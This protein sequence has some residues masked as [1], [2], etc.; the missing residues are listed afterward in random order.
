MIYNGLTSGV[1]LALLPLI[2]LA[3]KRNPQCQA[4]LA[5]RLGHA[6]A[7]SRFSSG[8]WPKIWIH[9]VSVGEVKV[10]DAIIRALDDGGRKAAIVLTTTTATGQRYAARTLGHR[11][12][13]CFA[14]LD[15]WSVTGRFLAF[16]RPDLL[17]CM[18]TEIW[19]NWIVRTHRI[20][21][22]TVF[23][24]GR[25]S[26]RS[27]RSYLAIRPLLKPVLENV[28]AFS[29][30]SDA[31]A[32]RI[33][34]LGAPAQKVLINGNVKMDARWADLDVA[35]VIKLKHLFAVDP[36][37]PVFVA[38]SVRGAEVDTLLDVYGRLAAQIPGLVF[39]IAPRHI[40][41]TSRIESL[42][43]ERKIHYQRRTLL[44]QTGGRRQAPVLIL[45]TIGELR[46]VY[47]LAS[48]VFCGASLVSLGGQNVFEPAMWAKPVLYGPFMDDFTEARKV[49]EEH[50]GGICVNDES[51][52]TE[53]ACHLLSHPETARRIGRLARQAVLS[54]HG[55]AHRHAQVVL[56]Q[57]LPDA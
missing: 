17:V 9:A 56:R 35:A 53:R 22:P 1:A 45:D 39:I 40:E 33:I 18:E 2:W 31:D 30:I 10:A 51:E 27:I 24:N 47:G 8:G 57:L 21:V 52:L 5:Q 3:G 7:A 54:S 44:D 36:Q 49:L 48:V 6:P 46:Q 14:P 38:G 16:H 32:R 19:P 55:A 25:I 34:A 4:A 41:K 13:V 23:L 12:T 20:G 15:L 28:A 42:A 43:R 11:A 26:A 50:G 29:M 37:T